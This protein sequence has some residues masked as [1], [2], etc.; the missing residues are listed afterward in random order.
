MNDEPPFIIVDGLK[1]APILRIPERV[2]KPWESTEIAAPPFGI[3]DRVSI[4]RAARKKYRQSQFAA[5]HLSQPFSWAPGRQGAT[6][7]DAS[8][9]LAKDPT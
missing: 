2:V 1:I 9:R 7:Y 3:V 4:S 6:T 8:A 5:V